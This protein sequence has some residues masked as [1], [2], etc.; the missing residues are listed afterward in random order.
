MNDVQPIRRDEL[1]TAESRN[2]QMTG[3]IDLPNRIPYN[4]FSDVCTGGMES[5]HVMYYNY[6]LYYDEVECSCGRKWWRKK[7]TGA[8]TLC[9]ICYTSNLHR[10]LEMNRDNL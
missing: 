7:N 8:Y 6:L 1:Q 2:S 9:G 4:E 3:R 5:E 10:L